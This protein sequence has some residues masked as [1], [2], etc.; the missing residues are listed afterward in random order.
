MYKF[1]FTN[2]RFKPNNHVWT[3]NLVHHKHY[4]SHTSLKAMIWGRSFG[5]RGFKSHFPN[6]IAC[7]GFEMWRKIPCKDFKI[8]GIFSWAE[9]KD[10]PAISVL[11]NTTRVWKTNVCY[12]SYWII[13]WQIH[14][15]ITKSCVCC[16]TWNGYIESSVLCCITTMRTLSF[17][18]AF[19]WIVI[20]VLPSDALKVEGEIATT[21]VS[22]VILYIYATI[23]FLLECV[24][25]FICIM[26]EKNENSKFLKWSLSYNF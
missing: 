23:L 3:C 20:Y 18:F 5:N 14:L 4:F 1:P 13:T 12:W 10:R 16:K 8:I 6:V 19:I 11:I 24:Y 22:C 15:N 17:C 25:I 9:K 7:I 26:I 2:K 21:D